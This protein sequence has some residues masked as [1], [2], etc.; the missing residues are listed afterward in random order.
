[1]PE[2]DPPLTLRDLD[3]IPVS[4]L[5]G[6]GEKRDQALA[7]AEIRSVLGLL[8]HYPR[9]HLDRS[10]EAS[11]GDL[12]PGE[13]ATVK[14]YEERNGKVVLIPHNPSLSEMVFDPSEVQL[15]GK[16]VTVMRKL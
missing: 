1:M 12:A 15:F 5:R 3:Q 6:V 10:R 8:T 11:I 16:V 9:R 14:T 2:G 4:R 7:G 13:E